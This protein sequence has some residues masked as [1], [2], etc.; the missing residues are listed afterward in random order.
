MNIRKL[1]LLIAI[2]LSAAASW[3]NYPTK[4]NISYNTADSL[5]HLLASATTAADSLPITVDLYDLLP[6][7]RQRE[8]MAKLTVDLALR[9]KNYSFG[10][11]AVRNLANSHSTDLHRLTL[12]REL[13]MKFPNSQDT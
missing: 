5:R 11:D 1:L 7:G 3:A 8:D 10:L 2:F 9:S 12:D 13:A 4:P 6:R